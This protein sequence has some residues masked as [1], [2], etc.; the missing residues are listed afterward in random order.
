MSG[1]VC[2]HFYFDTQQEVAME[3]VLSLSGLV[4]DEIFYF[5]GGVLI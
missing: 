4:T 3:C 2:N 1:T 5:K